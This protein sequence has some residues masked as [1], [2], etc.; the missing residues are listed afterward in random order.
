MAGI[1][2]VEDSFCGYLEF[3][4]GMIDGVDAIDIIG[5]WRVNPNPVTGV[6]VFHILPADFHPLS[7]CGQ[8][9]W[10]DTELYAVFC[11]QSARSHS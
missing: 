9:G 7:R 1:V 3:D 4:G 2:E 11:V 10:T 8:G 6:G 5:R